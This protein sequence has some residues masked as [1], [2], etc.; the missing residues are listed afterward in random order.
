VGGGTPKARQF[1]ATWAFR[2]A[3]FPVQESTSQKTGFGML[4]DRMRQDDLD[5]DEVI[6]CL[7]RGILS[8]SLHSANNTFPLLTKAE[9]ARF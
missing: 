5:L 6:S 7:P 8:I 3:S 2:S 9:G 4:K 1:A